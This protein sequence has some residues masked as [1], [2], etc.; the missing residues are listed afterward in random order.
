[1]APCVYL[2][3]FS[4]SASEADKPQNLTELE[5]ELQAVQAQMEV[6]QSQ[7]QN[8]QATIARLKATPQDQASIPGE[9]LHDEDPVELPKQTQ[10]MESK[11]GLHFYGKIKTDLIHDS[12]DLGN[13]EYILFIPQF[14]D[15]ESQT[16]FTARE[17]RLGFAL[18]DRPTGDWTTRARFESD[19]YGSAQSGGS[20]SLRLRLA[21]VEFQNGPT[22]IRIGQDWVP[23]ASLNPSTT[24][25]TIMGYGGNLWGR[26]PQLTLRH[27]ISDQLSGSISLFRYR[28]T[29]DVE[30]FCDT[31]LEMP[32]IAGKLG[33][34]P[35]TTEKATAY[36]GLSGAWRRGDVNGISVEP[37]LAAIEWKLPWA[38]FDFLGEAYWGEGLGPEFLHK[39][40]AFNTLGHA[41]ETRGGFLQL[42]LQAAERTRFHMG[43]GFDDPRNGDVLKCG[44]AN[45]NYPFADNFYQ[46]NTYLFGNLTQELGNDLSTVFEGSWIT[47]DWSTGKDEGFRFQGSM[48]YIW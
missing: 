43:Y 36:I 21:Y 9:A 6:M 37:K 28:D 25:F 42:G 40:G 15:G 7:I 16:S 4:L 45:P 38:P 10:V 22:A 20:G 44:P 18:D 23:V 27:E 26:V 41:I 17:T 11:Y 48:I 12:N 39:R 1:M 30:N 3:G 8:L 29:D 24:N 33:F 2:S 47:T 19:F 5:K 14:S 13:D 31:D 34:S 32:W 35:Y 46:K